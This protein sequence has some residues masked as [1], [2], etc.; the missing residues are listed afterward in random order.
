ML[1]LESD[2]G[3]II[4]GEVSFEGIL[5]ELGKVETSWVWRL[6]DVGLMLLLLLLGL[7]EDRLGVIRD[8]GLLLRM[9]LTSLAGGT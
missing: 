3:G 5:V 1:S 8:E 2:K 4:D 7:W 6:R 9:P